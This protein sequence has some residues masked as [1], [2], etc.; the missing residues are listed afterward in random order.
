MTDAD[1]QRRP[2]T[3]LLAA[4]I[5]NVLAAAVRM[6]ASISRVSRS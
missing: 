1:R 6:I 3:H 4:S 5:F 2:A